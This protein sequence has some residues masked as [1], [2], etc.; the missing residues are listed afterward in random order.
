[1]FEGDEW[2]KII[3][4]KTN[5][6]L[7]AGKITCRKDYNQLS[8]PYNCISFDSRWFFN[9]DTKDKFDVQDNPE[10]LVV[11]MRDEDIPTDYKKDLWRNN[12]EE[13]HL[14]RD[15][16]INELDPEVKDLVFALNELDKVKTVCSCSGHGDRPLSVYIIFFDF[17]PLCMLVKLIHDKFRKDFNLRTR[18]DIYN[19]KLDR[20]VLELETTTIGK[21]AFEKAQEM[22]K[23]LKKWIRAFQ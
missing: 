10:H 23:E 9:L 15:Y 19:S 12:I 17:K 5:K 3:D 7:A 20:V 16:D 13:M 2:A 18:P 22:T 21:E 6:V 14:Y 11:S 4:K 1:M 8:K